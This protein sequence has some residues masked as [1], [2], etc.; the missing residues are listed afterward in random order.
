MP[1]PKT[2]LHGCAGNGFHKDLVFLF[3]IGGTGNLR[4]SGA[5]PH[6]REHNTAIFAHRAQPFQSV[7]MLGD[8]CRGRN[9]ARPGN[10]NAFMGGYACRTVVFSSDR[11]FY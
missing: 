3:G 4:A 8:V 7:R 1:E 6:N 5:C 11:Y 10:A 2:S 9:S